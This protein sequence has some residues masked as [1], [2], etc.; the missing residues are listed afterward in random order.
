MALATEI[1]SS[2][3]PRLFVQ[4]ETTAM[5]ANV[6]TM[7]EVPITGLPSI[8]ENTHRDDEVKNGAGRTAK[9]VDG[10]T[11][12]KGQVKE[13]S[14]QQY[15]VDT[16]YMYFLQNGAG[17]AA[18]ATGEVLIAYNH[19]PASCG[20]GGSFTDWTGTMTV[21]YV[22]PFASEAQV[23]PGC[24]VKSLKKSASKGSEGGRFL[25]DVTVSTQEE[26]LTDQASPSST[27]AYTKSDKV[28]YD[29]CDT[30]QINSVDVQL[31]ATELT[32][33]FNPVHGGSVCDG[34]ASSIGKCIP[35]LAVTGSNT[36]LV[37][38]NTPDAHKLARTNTT[39]PISL[40]DGSDFYVTI[41]N[42]QINADVQPSDSNGYQVFVLPFK[43]KASTSGNMV[44]EQVG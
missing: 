16:Q 14:W 35:E 22:P 21:A 24:V 17:K 28:I 33:E 11:I 18:E 26:I 1:Y 42:A 27:Q 3:E 29:Y 37:D 32:Y 7:Y 19:T 39:V 15:M 43:A 2:K 25:V 5:T 38:S 40:S 20:N 10:V 9:V 13:I 4:A 31:E 8:P 23:I 12:T 36:I 6:A 41:A 44:D 34:G 30:A